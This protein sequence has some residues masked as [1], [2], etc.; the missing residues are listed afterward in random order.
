MTGDDFAL[1]S[2]VAS[3]IPPSV[4]L[5]SFLSDHSERTSVA[6]SALLS[7]VSADFLFFFSLT[8]IVAFLRARLKHS[9]L[10]FS[11]QTS[12]SRRS[13]SHLNK[14]VSLL[15]NNVSISAL[16]SIGAA[17]SQDSTPIHDS[18]DFMTSLWHLVSKA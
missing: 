11:V 6:S 17:P 9:C 10:V 13:F 16:I 2:C 7:F 18:C 14:L 15:S 5:F 12:P 8:G 4:D 1:C 3:I